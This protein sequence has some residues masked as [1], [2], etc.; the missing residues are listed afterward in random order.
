MG[1][2]VTCDGCE[3]VQGANDLGWQVWS[4]ASAPSPL[5]G[6]VR[7]LEQPAVSSVVASVLACSFICAKRAL[8][9]KLAEWTPEP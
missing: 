2:K 7:R 1:V 9:K 3:K 8:S 4:I 5:I 6:G